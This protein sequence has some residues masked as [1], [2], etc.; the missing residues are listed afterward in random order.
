MGSNDPAGRDDIAL[1]SSELDDVLNSA[2]VRSESGNDE[3]LGLEKYGVWIKVEPETLEARTGGDEDFAL[4]ELDSG[5]APDSKLTAE[6]EK[7][8]GEL[9]AEGEEPRAV[10][11]PAVEEAGF[12]GLEKELQ[13]LDSSGSGEEDL[14]VAD[15]DLDLEELSAEQAGEISA[16]PSE[17]EVPLSDS[18]PELDAEDAEAKLAG[19]RSA[20]ALLKKIEEDLKQIKREIQNLKR[21]LSGIGRGAGEVEVPHVQGAPGFFAE[22]EDDSIALTGDELD[23]ILNTADVTEEQAGAAGPIEDLS[24]MEPLEAAMETTPGGESLAPDTTPARG[25]PEDLELLEPGSLSAEPE[26]VQIEFAEK[27]SDGGGEAELLAEELPTAVE[28]TAG[29]PLDLEE[30]A[31][32]PEA[33]EFSLE[34]PLPTQEELTLEEFSGSEAPVEMLEPVESLEPAESLEPESLEPAESLEP[35]ETLEPLESL[36]PESLEPLE[37]LEALT[38]PDAVAELEAEE[39]PEA[40][41]PEA[42]EAAPLEAVEEPAAELDLD[43]ELP[44]LSLAPGAEE[45]TPS[46]PMELELVEE[47]AGGA[48][49][50]EQ[51]AP[52]VRKPGVHPASASATLPADMREDVKSVLSY[53][54][55]LLDALPTEKVEEFAHS[56][57]WTTYKKLFEELG[58]GS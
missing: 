14:T 43:E 7:L 18:I 34:E 15:L 23:N 11:A 6:E 28:P 17:V 57:H 44:D 53:L 47:Q 21:E 2:E 22:E 8:L 27:P 19:G 29:E 58:L 1:S 16:E 45:E 49:V 39:E 42:V 30:L 38:E 12:E 36:E 26:E 33:E 32:V 3:E 51:Q 13:E 40:A 10:E 25:Q 55:Q 37:S 9:E 54:D 52:A 56:Q 46:E 20:D 41:E 50:L 5:P 35:T 31:E 4:E 24:P 48:P